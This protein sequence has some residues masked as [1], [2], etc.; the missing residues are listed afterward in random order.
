MQLSLEMGLKFT[1]YQRN[2][3]HYHRNFT[4]CDTW[5]KVKASHK[6][7]AFV[8]LKY[9]DFYGLLMLLLVLACPPSP[10]LWRSLLIKWRTWR[11][12]NMYS[13]P[14]FLLNPVQ[15]FKNNLL[16]VEASIVIV[17]KSLTQH[18]DR[19]Y[20]FGRVDEIGVVGPA[21]DEGAQVRPPQVWQPCKACDSHSTWKKN[22]WPN[23]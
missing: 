13:F 4:A 16:N 2:I 20:R 8:V 14:T 6:N 5:N 9:D 21:A 19:E 7:R 10:S 18:V 12:T 22:G 11:K 15:Y 1:D 3:G 17:I 23:W